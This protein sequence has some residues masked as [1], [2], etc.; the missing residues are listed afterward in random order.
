MLSRDYCVLGVTV[1]D[2]GLARPE[3]SSD[4]SI[5]QMCNRGRVFSLVEIDRT[6]IVSERERQAITSTI[7]FPP[8][9]IWRTFFGV[10]IG[11]ACVNEGKAEGGGGYG[12][13]TKTNAHVVGIQRKQPTRNDSK[14]FVSRK[15]DACKVPP[16][17]RERFLLLSF[18]LIFRRCTAISTEQLHACPSA[19]V[20]IDPFS[21][22]TGR[23]AGF[24]RSSLNVI[25]CTG[26][27]LAAIKP[28]GS[29]HPLSPRL[30]CRPRTVRTESVSP[31]PAPLQPGQLE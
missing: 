12:G 5:N 4:T 7:A 20:C 23:F 6:L 15:S 27:H 13:R 30:A 3:A 28:A 21:S 1:L 17:T 11:R 29:P 31:K 10:K 19:S 24:P 2:Y 26:V 18:V 8:R 9:E 22:I 14:P 16:L 25:Q